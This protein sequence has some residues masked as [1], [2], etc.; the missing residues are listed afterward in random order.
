MT[1]QK[2]IVLIVALVLMAAVGA[3]LLRAG[4]KRSL[5][6]PGVKVLKADT[7]SGLVVE[8]PERIRQYSSSNQPPA[9][10][11]LATLPKD[12]SFGRRLYQAPGGQEILLSVVLMGTDRTSIHKPEF[13]LEAQG[14][15]ILR[16]EWATVQVPHPQPYDLAVRKFTSSIL[17][18]SPGGVSQRWSGVYVFWFVS[19]ER[20]TASHW[21]RM[22]YLTWDLLRTGRLPRWAYISCFT[23]CPEG[24][25][26]VAFDRVKQFIAAAVPEFQTIPTDA[27]PSRTRDLDRAD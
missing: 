20:L 9:E 2:W 11:E 23:W 6:E 1:R 12:T 21:E 17:V 8:L 27:T 3:F 10:I 24:G 15:Q 13:C 5:G 7:P 25:E 14:W 16:R 26:E 4:A 18:E 22:G 19:A